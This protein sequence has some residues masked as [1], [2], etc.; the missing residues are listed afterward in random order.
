MTPEQVKTMLDANEISPR[1]LADAE[2]LGINDDVY[3]GNQSTADRL[4]DE[5]NSI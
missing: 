1:L 5:W 3:D 2:D 4:D